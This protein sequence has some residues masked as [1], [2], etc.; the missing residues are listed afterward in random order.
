[1]FTRTR[2]TPLKSALPW[3][4]FIATTWA[5]ISSILL[6]AN[7]LPFSLLGLILSIAL[8]RTYLR[9][10]EFRQIPTLLRLTLLVILIL[11]TFMTLGNL[12]GKQAGSA[13][14][15]CMIVLKLIETHSSR[16]ARVVLMASC[17]L[18]LAG[19]LY[20]QSITQTLSTAAACI[21]IFAALRQITAPISNQSKKTLFNWS[22]LGFATR[23]LLLAT[24]FAAVCF[25]LFPRL[26]TPLW[27]APQ[28]S[29]SA[30]TGIS[31]HMEPGAFA[32]LALDD[33]PVFRVSF[34]GQLPEPRYRYFRGPVLWRFDGSAWSGSEAWRGYTSPTE[35]QS[36]GTPIGY[37]IIQEPTDQRWLFPLD[38]PIKAPDQ[39]T[40]T[41][42]LQTLST[43]A[44][45]QVL[46]YQGIS[47]TRYI[48]QPK[49]T[50][51]QRSISLQL[52]DSLNPRARALASSWRKQWNDNP[53]AIAQAALDLFTQNFSYS[54][55]VPLLSRD[56][57]IDDFLWNVRSGW[58][59]HYA[60]SFTFLMRAA[61]IPAR[62]VTGFQGGF[63]N[64]RG[65]YLTLRRSDAHAWSEIWV[66]DEGWIRIDPTA[67]IAPERISND[68]RSTYEAS[69]TWYG[70]S[71]LTQ[72]RDRTDLLAYW[73][74]QTIVEFSAL[75][76]KNLLHQFGIDSQSS[77]LPA[78][79]ILFSAAAL[80]GLAWF[81]QGRYRKP[82]DRLLQNWQQLCALL[83]RSGIN[84]E[85][86]E[87]PIEFTRRAAEKAPHLANA[88]LSIGQHYARLRYAQD[89]YSEND[90]LSL[91][92][93]V[94]ALRLKLSRVD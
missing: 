11:S 15:A 19:F 58:C 27:G 33:T 66:E 23:Y 21:F 16:D 67:A 70:Q 63:Y 91:K 4:A 73:W 31:D 77:L 55:E 24:P 14:L 88:L 87:G 1:M 41:A 62:V 48:L 89:S 12:L 53:K 83:A 52:P 28:D 54:F 29:Y 42:D 60:S 75:R 32:N 64:S 76:Q 34:D 7:A 45:S 39:A 68:A 47:A 2:P 22:D 3:P 69:N 61:G 26:S 82:R 13:L 43:Q 90:I 86:C 72:W 85:P 30:R 92:M 25:V 51:N 18:A 9:W 71:W 6:H 78:L 40:L 8:L 59:E 49:L 81:A 10:R 80:M 57:A 20:D 5:A 35:V 65:N 46:R 84:K 79:L 37:T 36:L 17:F 93:Q 38:V 56:H 74:T 50:L 44:L 94:K